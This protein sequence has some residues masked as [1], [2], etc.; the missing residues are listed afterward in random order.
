MRLGQVF[1]LL[2]ALAAQ[3]RP[4][5][6][7]AAHAR[8]DAHLPVELEL[9]RELGREVEILRRVVLRRPEEELPHLA[10]VDR[11]HALVDLVHAA[12]RHAVIDGVIRGFELRGLVIFMSDEQSF[13]V[14]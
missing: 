11:V 4:L 3:P 9:A 7:G 14:T 5:P 8:K 10:L 6:V 2:V 12:E 13:T 1:A